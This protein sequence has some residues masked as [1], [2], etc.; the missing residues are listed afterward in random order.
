MKIYRDFV[1]FSVCMVNRPN[2]TLRIKPPAT[3]RAQLYEASDRVMHLVK[4]VDD[5]K[6]IKLSRKITFY[7]TTVI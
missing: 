3:M 6:N 7:M 4:E 5:I 2:Q 1:G